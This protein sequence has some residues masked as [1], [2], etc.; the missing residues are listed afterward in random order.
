VLTSLGEP[1][2]VKDGTCVLEQEGEYVF[3][4]Q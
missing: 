2:A 4:A 3:T 1:P